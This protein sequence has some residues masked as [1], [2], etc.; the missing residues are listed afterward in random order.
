MTTERKAV[1]AYGERTAERYLRAQGLVVL[2]RNWRRPEGEVDLILRDGDDVV[3]CEVKTRRG[4]HF[5]T[6]AEAIGPAKVRRLRRLAA[7]WLAETSIRPHEIR[8]DVVAVLPQRRGATVVE[9]V[10]AAF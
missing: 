4:D 10:R 7:R 8:F 9:H 6:P 1:G 3:F 2:A 5:G